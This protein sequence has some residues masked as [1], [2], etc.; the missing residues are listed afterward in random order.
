MDPQQAQTAKTFDSY[1]ETYSEA[2]G[3]SVSFTGLS[4]DFF[5][6]V[7]ADYIGDIV[8]AHFGRGASLA[9]LDVGCGVGNYHAL[10][11]PR[12]GTLSGVDVS[13]AC[14]ETARQRN[15]DVD[16]KVYDGGALPYED[17]TFDVAFTICVLHHVPPTQW[18]NFAREMRRVLKPGGLGLVFEHNPR[19]PLT[20]RAVNTCPFD[21]DAVL[22]RN[23]ETE[24]LLQE[25]G[26]SRT[27]S[28]FILSVPPANVILRRIDRMFSGLPFGGQY[29]VAATA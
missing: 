7:K 8:D 11:K 19:N 25:A 23:E 20:M 10:L 14:V 12:F 16:Y 22:L 17:A 15:A 5:T 18:K 4:A 6:R 13:G 21:E 24:R 9:A 26:F 27:R 1:K 3:A 28:R 29:Y 2:V